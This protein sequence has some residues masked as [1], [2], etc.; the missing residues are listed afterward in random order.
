MP[1]ETAAERRAYHREWYRKNKAV[2]PGM[3]WRDRGDLR[4]CTVCG[5][6]KPREKAFPR[7][8]HARLGFA[9]MCQECKNKKA[10]G[11]A[12]S[13]TGLT[14]EQYQ[15]Y[16]RE[17]TCFICD[18]NKPRMAVDHCHAT[19]VKRGVLCPDCNKGL[20]HFK[21]DPALLQAAIEYLRKPR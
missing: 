1:F 5:Q 14:R 8:D 12:P 19:Q 10:H 13:W 20:G 16:V 9:S 4:E 11:R 17:G 21:D 6:L 3:V 18:E 15:N 7:L 2:R